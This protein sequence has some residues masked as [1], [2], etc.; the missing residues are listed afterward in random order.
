MGVL[1]GVD[2][3]AERFVTLDIAAFRTWASGGLIPHARQG[4]NGVW[5]LAV[6]GS[7]LEGTGFE[8][9]QMG[10]IQVAL[11]V[12]D[13]S[14][15]GRWN[16]LSERDSGDAVALLDGVLRLDTFLFWTED[17]L[18]GFGTRVIFEE[19]FMKPAC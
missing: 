11:L 18:E 14:G 3:C 15:V 10:H 4:A 5:A 1:T 16:G 7:K 12:G 13:G 8:K 9:E 2:D 17:R 19:D 6:V